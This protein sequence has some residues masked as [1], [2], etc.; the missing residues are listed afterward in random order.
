[1][2]LQI[3]QFTTLLFSCYHPYMLERTYSWKHSWTQNVKIE[4]D[5][6]CEGCNLRCKDFQYVSDG[7]FKGTRGWLTQ[8]IDHLYQFTEK[9]A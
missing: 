1:M 2:Y 6:T 8:E 7:T 4:F 3:K 9:T 5:P